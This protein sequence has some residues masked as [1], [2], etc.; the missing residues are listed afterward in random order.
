MYEGTERRRDPR[1]EGK[2]VISYRVLEEEDNVDITQTKNIGLGGMLLTTNRDFPAGTR[3]ALEIRL[4]LDPD[5]IRV[6]ARV[7]DSKK[8]IS[9][10]IYNTRLAFLSVDEKHKDIIGKTVNYYLKQE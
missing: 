9:G 7:V 10:L 2:F 1:A 6:V 8:V 4:P 5:P 3:L